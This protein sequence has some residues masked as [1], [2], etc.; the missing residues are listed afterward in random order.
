MFLAC[1]SRIH[2]RTISLRFLGIILRV[3]RL[4]V[5][6]GFLS[7]CPP[8]SF[9]LKTFV[10]ISSKNSASD[11]PPKIW[12]NNWPTLRIEWAHSRPPLLNCF[13]PYGNIWK[14]S[15]VY[16]YLRTG[17]VCIYICSLVRPKQ[18][19]VPCCSSTKSRFLRILCLTPPPHTQRKILTTISL[20]NH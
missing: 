3:L 6:H 20:V 19:S 7:G 4:E 5:L 1:W 15:Y 16:K 9:T 12:R 8:F 18:P 13:K 2:E 17:S 11:V 14:Y 10:W